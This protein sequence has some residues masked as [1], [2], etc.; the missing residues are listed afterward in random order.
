MIRS[1]P[2]PARARVGVSLMFL[3]NGAIFTALL[4]RYP[5]VKQAFDLSNTGFGLLVVAFPVGAILAATSAAPLIRRYGAR[6]LVA[7]GSIAIAAAVTAAGFSPSVWFF[8]LMLVMGGATDAV[9][10]AAQN[11]HGVL[12]ER[13]AGRS[14]INSFHAVWSLGA[15]I[16][17]GVGALG[18]ALDVRLGV[19]LLASG[20]VWSLV[21]LLA[22]HLALVPE[23]AAPKPGTE[24]AAR[25][26]ADPE[27]ALHQPRSGAWRLLAPVVVLAVCGT[28]VEDVANNWSV[29]FLGL[30]T[31]APRGVAALAVTIVLVFQF[32]GRIVGDPM[33]DRW[34]RGPVARTGGLLIAAGALMALLSPWWPLA[35]L[36]FGLG[37]F[38]CATLVPAAFVAADQVP[39]LPEG[40]GIAVLGWLMRLGFLLTSPVVGVISDASSL[41]VALLVPVGA[42]LLAAVMAQGLATRDRRPRVAAAPV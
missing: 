27:P 18:A 23:G 8:A 26:A 14:V 30:E 2:S 41:R 29:L 7:V 5:E 36:G 21:A 10:D 42:G 9:T 6:R 17:G 24:P 1:A 32:V 13:W 25:P 33:T 11:V 16:G 15:A 39:G 3:T 4:P 34:G 38:G 40:T 20:V 12:V 35:L 37:G 22:S 31:D 28:L 19:Q